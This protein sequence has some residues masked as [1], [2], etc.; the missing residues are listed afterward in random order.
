MTFAIPSRRILLD[1]STY[2]FDFRQPGTL[3][4]D[5]SLTRASTGWYFNSTP[6]LASAATDA[7]RWNYNPTSGT[8]EGLL[9]E[10]AVTN[11][12][13]NA[14]GT[15]GS[16][17]TLPTNWLAG[18]SL[19]TMTQTVTSGQSEDG[20]ACV[21]V[22]INGTPNATSSRSFEFDA[23]TQIAALAAQTWVSSPYVR[24][25][26]GALTNTT[27]THQLREY[28]AAGATVATT[29][30]TITPTSAALRTQRF[31][32]TRLLTGGTTAF[33]NSY[34]NVAYTSGLAVDLTLRIFA[35][36]GQVAT[37]GSPIVS[38]G[39]A[40]VTR[41][42]DALSLAVRNGTY[43]VDILRASGAQTLLAQVVSAGTYAVPNDTSPLQTVTLR[44][45]S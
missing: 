33:V 42:A 30:S 18:G 39:S 38:T 40:A 21:D 22:R 19:A 1:G 11:S 37:A 26:A 5:A 24:L 35:Q 31:D 28:T 17:S 4:T 29:S 36:L 32:T 44:K 8:L 27:V 16:G 7:G 9:N 12:L 10:A 45:V 3:P 20:F 25:S 34:V 6:A 13:R 14:T 2:V 41:A 43:N 15:G 23:R